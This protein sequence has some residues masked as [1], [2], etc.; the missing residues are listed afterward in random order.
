MLEWARVIHEAIGIE[1][2]RAFIGRNF[3]RRR[4][5]ARLGAPDSYASKLHLVPPGACEWKRQMVDTAADR[6]SLE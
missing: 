5:V 4:P 2:P 3:Q 1:S 6:G